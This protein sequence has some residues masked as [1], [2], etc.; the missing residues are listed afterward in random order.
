MS[1]FKTEWDSHEDEGRKKRYAKLFVAKGK[2]REAKNVIAGGLELQYKTIC[3]R[4][5]REIKKSLKSELKKL[6]KL[7]DTYSGFLK[8][9]YKYLN[10]QSG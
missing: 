5:V 7:M 9:T 10:W 8:L 2:K 1:Y 6:G 3:K 4:K